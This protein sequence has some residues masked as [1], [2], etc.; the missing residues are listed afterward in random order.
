MTPC[1]SGWTTIGRRSCEGAVEDEG[2]CGP[3]PADHVSFYQG[4]QRIVKGGKTCGQS[5][6]E[7]HGV[8]G[9]K[10]PS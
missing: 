2:W 8:A 3:F 5:T 10:P 1:E 6:S 7:G 4:R 9:G